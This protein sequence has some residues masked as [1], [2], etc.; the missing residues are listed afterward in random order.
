MI[1]YLLRAC[2][3]ERLCPPEYIDR[4]RFNCSWRCRARE[5]FYYH[6]GGQVDFGEEHSKACGHNTGL[7]EY[8]THVGIPKNTIHDHGLSEIPFPLVFVYMAVLIWCRAL[9]CVGRAQPSVF[10]RALCWRR[11]W[12]CIRCLPTRYTDKRFSVV[13]TSDSCLLLRN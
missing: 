13:L 10:C 12:G 5:L 8:I 1:W 3:L 9:S 4:W 7:G 11:L 2:E 6:K